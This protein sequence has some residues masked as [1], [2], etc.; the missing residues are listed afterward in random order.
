MFNARV[1]NDY[2]KE[3]SHFF[4]PSQVKFDVASNVAFKDVSYFWML[5]YDT[6]YWK[7]MFFDVM[8]LCNE[9][10][11]EAWVNDV[12]VDIRENFTIIHYHHKLQMFIGKQCVYCSMS[13]IQCSLSLPN[14]LLL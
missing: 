4:E 13:D 1:S 6:G 2:K 8:I 5:N 9:W 7:R 11:K 10:R 14:L 12:C 3:L